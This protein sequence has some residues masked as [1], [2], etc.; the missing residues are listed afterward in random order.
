M[1]SW[2]PTATLDILKQRAALIKKTRLF[3]EKS[4]CLEVET[5]IL[6]AHTVTDPFLSSFSTF[7]LNQNKTYYLQTSPEYAMK[8]LLAANS[9]PIFQITKAFRQDEKGSR[10]NPEFTILEWYMPHYDHHQLMDHMSEYLIFML[11]CPTPKKFSYAKIFELYCKINPH[12]ANISDLKICVRENNLD[13]AP[14]GELENDKDTWLDLLMS[15]CIEPHLGCDE[16]VFIYDYPAPQAALSISKITPEGY[17]VGE[18]FEVYYQG[19]ELA[20]G[21]HELRDASEQ[22]KRFEANLEKRRQLNLPELQLDFYFL[23]ALKQGEFPD[24]SGV[25]LGLDRLFM[26]IL[27]K[28]TIADVMSFTIENA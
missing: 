6:S 12:L 13:I 16:P 15:H 14:L 17:A 26:L 20:N 23:E 11:S 1:T 5:P 21:F 2:K 9:G 22:K 28:K 8:R 4:G 7:A 3:F 24:V 25:A 27:G 18:R 10:H 19:I